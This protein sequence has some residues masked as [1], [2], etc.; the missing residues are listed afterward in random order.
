MSI[1]AIFVLKQY[2]GSSLPDGYTRDRMDQ[3]FDVTMPDPVCVLPL[4]WGKE[5]VWFSVAKIS[6]TNYYLGVEER[7]NWVDNKE[8]IILRISNHPGDWTQSGALIIDSAE[9]TWGS[10]QYT[11]PTFV[12]VEGTSNEVISPADFF[13][14]G[15]H[16][17]G[18][19]VLKARRLSIKMQ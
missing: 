6:G 13:I 15:N 11:Y 1:I 2:G 16:P 18:G 17:N 8:E 5:T 3:F 4:E 10:S 7:V 19:H 9:G 14:I 12:N